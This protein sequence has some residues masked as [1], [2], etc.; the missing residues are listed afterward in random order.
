VTCP[1]ELLAHKDLG[2]VFQSLGAL[3][4]HRY[5]WS[6]DLEA[7]LKVV[8]KGSVCVPWGHCPGLDQGR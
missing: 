6:C 3:G 7:T 2:Y 1:A 5:E 4:T 8:A